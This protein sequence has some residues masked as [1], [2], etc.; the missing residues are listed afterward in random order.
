MALLEVSGV[1]RPWLM[2]GSLTAGLLSMI[3][4]NC[5]RAMKSDGVAAEPYDTLALHC[6]TM[7]RASG[8]VVAMVPSSVVAK[9]HSKTVTRW[10]V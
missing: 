7:L 4:K 9:T 5:S 1:S 2:D 8:Y 6:S 3:L 10:S